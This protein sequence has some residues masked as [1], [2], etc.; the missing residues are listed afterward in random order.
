MGEKGGQVGPA[1]SGG[2]FLFIPRA[3]GS[4]Q[5]L[6][7]DGGMTSSCCQIPLWLPHYLGP[8]IHHQSSPAAWA[9]MPI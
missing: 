7:V 4:Q 8:Q 6:E 2:C 5:R 9:Y 3:Q 1:G